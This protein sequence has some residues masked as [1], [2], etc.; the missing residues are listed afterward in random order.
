MGPTGN[1]AQREPGYR[2]QYEAFADWRYVLPHIC[3]HGRNNSFFACGREIGLKPLKTERKQTGTE[4][5]QTV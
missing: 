5:G 4:A 2:R 3:A 1:A